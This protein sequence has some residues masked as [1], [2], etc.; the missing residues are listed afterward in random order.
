MAFDDLPPR[1]EP[2]FAA[3]RVYA[4][5][6]LNASRQAA[7]SGALNFEGDI[8]FGPDYFQ[9][10]DV[11]SPLT[12]EAG[13]PVLLFLHGGAFIGG[14]KE[15]MGFM[16]PAIL[17]TPAVFVS[18]SYRLAP[19]HCF[20]AQLE[21]TATA[22]NWAWHNISRFGGDPERLFIGGHSAGGNLASVV[23]LD[24]RWLSPYDLPANVIKGVM[25][26]STPYD[27]QYE[28]WDPANEAALNMRRTYAPNDE[29]AAL[30]SPMALA[31]ADAPPFYLAAGDC[32][33][34]KLAEEMERFGSR[35]QQ[36]GVPAVS[37]RFIGHDHFD[38]N[39]RCVEQGHGW[40]RRTQSFLRDGT[41]IAEAHIAGKSPR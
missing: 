5:S 2:I 30:I 33:L 8:A 11:Y 27:L 4:Q 17:R 28:T 29:D 36:L 23:A 18:V 31:T 38:T 32:D 20:P 1:P 6:V 26:V 13:L 34:W 40:I 35:L 39:S 21:D 3:A 19:E 14:Y 12:G 7:E 10:V 9:R 16:A 22:V 41:P 25:P 15:W 37:E 24:K